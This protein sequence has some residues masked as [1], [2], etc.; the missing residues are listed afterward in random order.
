MA[1]PSGA[2]IVAVLMGRRLGLQGRMTVSYVLATVAIVLFVEG[3][4]GA[5]VLPR[6]LTG[7]DVTVRALD[8]AAVRA[9]ELS[10]LGL[11]PGGALSVS[12]L[13]GKAA[14]DA[15]KEAGLPALDA[16]E[17][18]TTLVLGSRSS[19][20]RLQSGV[21][22]HCPPGTTRVRHLDAPA[23]DLN[24]EYVHTLD[25]RRSLKHKP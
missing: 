3:V 18:S 20:E 12:S 16:K 2:G 4:A 13:H 23:P 6:V 15:T 25:L 14:G 17:G 9:K 8:A 7:Q 19:E 24:K 22:L 5:L 1:R 11:T 10:R 21:V